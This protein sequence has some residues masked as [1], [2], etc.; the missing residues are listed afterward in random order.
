[1]RRLVEAFAVV[2]CLASCSSGSGEMIT[3]P[4][5]PFGGVYALRLMNAAELPLYFSP[6]WYP[7]QG[8]SPGLQYTTVL[9]GDLLVRPDGTYTWSTMLEEVVAKPQTTLTGEYVILKIRREANGTWKYTESTG[10]LSLEG[11]DQFGPYV[12]TGSATNRELALTSTFIGRQNS[13]FVLAR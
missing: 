11:I 8:S 7:G 2:A 10:A 3:D 5:A 12:L 13:T 1:M 4:N 9:S 6:A